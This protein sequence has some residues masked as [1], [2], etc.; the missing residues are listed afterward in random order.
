MSQDNIQKSIS[1]NFPF[2]NDQERELLKELVV[3]GDPTSA[4]FQAAKRTFLEL[5][6]N[7]LVAF[8]KWESSP[9]DRI[10]IRKRLLNV[11]GLFFIVPIN[12][13]RELAHRAKLTLKKV[14]YEVSPNPLTKD[15]TEMHSYDLK[16]I[17]GFTTFFSKIMIDPEISTLDYVAGNREKRHYPHSQFT[18]FRKKI[19][20]E[21]ISKEYLTAS[22]EPLTQTQFISL[23]NPNGSPRDLITIGF[24][25]VYESAFIDYFHQAPNVTPVTLPRNAH[26]MG[27]HFLLSCVNE[28]I[29][30]KRTKKNFLDDFP[31]FLFDPTGT[32]E[33]V[34]DLLFFV[35]DNLIPQIKQK[36]RHWNIKL[37]LDPENELI[38]WGGEESATLE[39]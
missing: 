1:E 39:E 14:V 25:M 18:V 17:D 28:C 35:T 37:G 19:Q 7:D 12:E 24:D 4:R 13:L 15:V 22:A 8:Y 10:L 32:A 29:R 38:H 21:V 16:Y 33:R 11:A 26:I 3:Q 2:Y 27:K 9:D 6:Y 23:Y 34:D 30:L 20:D 31:V 36:I 5:L